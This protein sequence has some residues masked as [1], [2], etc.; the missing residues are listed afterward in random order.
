MQS[1]TN[2]MA[3]AA[4]VCGICGFLCLIPGVVGIILGGVSLPQIKRSGQAGRG[5][6]I[7]G[8]VMGVLWIVA[9]ILL[10]IFSHH[11]SQPV[12]TTGTGNGT[13]M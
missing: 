2:G 11:T 13:S 6:A 9:F 4:M 8:M 12:G 5:M 3:I 10:I 1:G 7:T